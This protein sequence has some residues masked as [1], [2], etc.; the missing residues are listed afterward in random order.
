MQ[1]SYWEWEGNRAP[2]K[3]VAIPDLECVQAVAELLRI[4]QIYVHNT[5]LNFDF[6]LDKCIQHTFCAARQAQMKLFHESLNK[7]AV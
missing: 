3:Y 7:S 1:C 2:W 5:S 4:L 6:D